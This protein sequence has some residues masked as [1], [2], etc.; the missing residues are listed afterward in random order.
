M[1]VSLLSLA[2][3]TTRLFDDPCK[4]LPARH[5]RMPWYS[6]AHP[7]WVAILEL[8]SFLHQPGCGGLTHIEALLHLFASFLDFDVFFAYP[9]LLQ[10]PAFSLPSSLFFFIFPQSSFSLLGLLDLLD[11]LSRGGS[12]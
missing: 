12:K 9:P 7:A 5:S 4:D 6:A 8:V 10:T 3:S 1:R 2:H 11:M